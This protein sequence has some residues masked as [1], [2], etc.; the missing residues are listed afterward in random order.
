MKNDDDDYDD[1]MRHYAKNFAA[2]SMRYIVDF[3]ENNKFRLR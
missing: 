1:D 3:G 2:I